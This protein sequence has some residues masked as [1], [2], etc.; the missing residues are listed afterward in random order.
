VV[1]ELVEEVLQRLGVA[2]GLG[3]HDRARGVVADLGQVA[4]AAAVADLVAA[5]RHQAR[6]A[7]GVEVIADHPLDDRADGVPADAQQAADRRLGH[8]LGHEGHQVLEVAGVPSARPR[9]GQ[10]LDAHPTIRAAHATQLVLDE[11]A[12]ATQIEM[13]PAP[14]RAIMNP[15]AD[16]P[17]ARAHR[18]APT[19]RD[20]CDALSPKQHIDDASA[21]ERQQAVECG[22]DPHAVLLGLLTFEQPAACRNDARAGR[23]APAQPPTTSPTQKMPAP[24]RVSGLK[25][26]TQTTGDPEVA[27]SPSMGDMGGVDVL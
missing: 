7:V 13:A 18:A 14:P 25:R 23:V 22:R 10:R 15:P 8:L 26:S 1:A 5:D 12:L 24:R 21:L 11:A 6:E 9:P 19:Q 17:A 2:A 16:L 4:L 27:S 20:A 3:P